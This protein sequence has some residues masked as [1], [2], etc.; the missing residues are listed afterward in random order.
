MMRRRRRKI[1][2]SF[3]LQRACRR[4]ISL[5]KQLW[6]QILHTLGAARVHAIPVIELPGCSDF[7]EPIIQKNE[8]ANKS[9][10]TCT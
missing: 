5:P 7:S 2:S 10:K 1:A 9:K 6:V 8:L 3:A 4:R